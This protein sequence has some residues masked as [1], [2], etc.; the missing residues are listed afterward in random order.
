[1]P[2]V[3][4]EIYQK[5]P[6][7]SKESIMIS[8]YP[9]YNKEEVFKEETILIDNTLEFVTLFRNKKLELNINKDYKVMIVK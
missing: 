8:S 4:E 2:Y 6:I 9:T 1:M 7:K 3:T 5:L